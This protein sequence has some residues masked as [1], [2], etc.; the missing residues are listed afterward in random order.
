[1]DRVPPPKIILQATQDVK[2]AFL[3]DEYGNKPFTPDLHIKA[4]FEG[5]QAKKSGVAI[6]VGVKYQYAGLC[7]GDLHRYGVEGQVRIPVIWTREGTFGDRPLVNVIPVIGYG[8]IKRS[9]TSAFDSFEAGLDITWQI[10]NHLGLVWGHYITDRREWQD[11]RY[12]MS[13]GLR[14]GL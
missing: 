13:A 7:S 5:Y 1:M 6:A 10:N 4:L 12:N 8:R 11:V 9:F 2:L 3:K 14:Y